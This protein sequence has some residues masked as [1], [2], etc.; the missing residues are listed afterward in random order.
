MILGIDVGNYSL[1]SNSGLNV[2]ALV[3]K[4]ENILGSGIVLEMDSSKFIIGEGN[5]ETELN[6]SSK[7]NFLPLLYTGIA[8]SSEEDFNSVVCGLP[9]NQ[10]KDNHKSLEE[11]INK[12]KIK[13]IRINGRKRTLV[14]DNFKVYPEGIGAYYNLNLSEDVILIDIGGRTTD[15]AYIADK[16]H[17]KSS[18]VAVGTLNI[19]KSIA[20]TINSKYSLDLS[21]KDIDRVI[22][23][24]TLKVDAETV[25]LS[26]ITNILKT[27]F[28]K[29]KED[30]DFKFPARTEK[31]VL[32]GGGA[33]LFIK[34]F[35]NRYSNCTIADDPIYSNAKGFKKVGE[36]LWQN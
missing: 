18:T 26:F 13:N 7:D 35:M 11:L 16:K 23:R 34:A 36:K 28:M 19:Y 9:V 17:Q 30:L 8:L 24:G 6:K 4:E 14:I 21:L 33:K 15:I 10:Y 25:N 5:F 31:I 20:D 12:N 29:I 3:S 2:K 32:V 22:D 27:N 1:K